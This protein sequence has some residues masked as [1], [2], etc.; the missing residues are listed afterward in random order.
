MIHVSIDV[1]ESQVWSGLYQECPVVDDIIEVRS[2]DAFVL[3]NRI[4]WYK[5][6]SRRW[7]SYN[8]NDDTMDHAPSG[9]ASV[10]LVA[11]PWEP[12]PER[13]EFPASGTNARIFQDQAKSFWRLEPN[14]EV[15][16]AE[17]GLDGPIPAW[18]SSGV[19]AFRWAE[20]E[21]GPMKEWKP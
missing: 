15:S 14:G 20:R 10:A 8:Y 12:V 7:I 1:N 3:E 2:S 16:W 4:A 9:V 21:M 11:V 13:I 5:V 17:P 18:I 6:I 19:T